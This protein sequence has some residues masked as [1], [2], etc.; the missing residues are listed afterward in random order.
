MREYSASSPPFGKALAG[1][2]SLELFSWLGMS[3]AFLHTSGFMPQFLKANFVPIGAKS[4]TK[5]GE[6]NMLD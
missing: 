1:I 5:K 4:D 3:Q 6:D 2:G